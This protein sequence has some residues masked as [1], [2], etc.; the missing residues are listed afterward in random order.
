MAGAA[1]REGYSVTALDAFADLDNHPAVNTHAVTACSPGTLV[2]AS[3]AVLCN[4]VAYLSPFENAPDAVDALA[5]GRTLWGNPAD[6]LRAARDPKR[7]A[8]VFARHDLPYPSLGCEEHRP[9]LVKPLASGGGHGIERWQAGADVPDGYYT[10]EFIDGQPGS[11]AFVA[12]PAGVAMLGVFEQLIGLDTFGAAGFRYCGSI[13]DGS[14]TTE[15][16]LWRAGSAVANVVALEFGLIG[17]NGIDFIATSGALYPIEVNP[18]WSSS[19]ELVER[20]L[21]VSVFAAHV[22][23]CTVGTL[24]RVSGA[25]AAIG[26]SIGKAVLFARHSLTVG[27]TLPWCSDATVRDIPRPGTVIS[28]GDPVCTVFAE[29][30]TASRCRDALEARAARIYSQLREWA[31]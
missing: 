26:R 13:M 22:E 7:L 16:W 5:R 29:G 27:D 21:N 24:P 23:A 9:C 20:A 6:V 15:S 19:M 8:A 1:A 3:R 30:L 31:V 18:R 4:A 25:G 2:E 14:I 11:V 12:S 10:Q 28:T 17:V